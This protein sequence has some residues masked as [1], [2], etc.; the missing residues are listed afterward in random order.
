MSLPII[1]LT[2]FAGNYLN[3]NITE[4]KKEPEKKVSANQIPNGPDIYTSNKLQEVNEVLLKELK[5]NYKKAENP[6]ETGVLPPN[7][8][9]LNAVGYNNSSLIGL[10]SIENAK[11][12][13]INKLSAV[14]KQPAKL[15]SARPMFQ[16]S[17]VAPRQE[18]VIQEEVSLLTG[19]PLV[20]EHSNMTPF[21]GSNIRQNT[22]KFTNDTILSNHTGV[23]SLY[24]HKKEISPLFEPMTENIYGTPIV[25]DKVI[26][27]E[28]YEAS[29][30]RSNEKPFNEQRISAPIANTIDNNIRP[31]Y[32]DVNE[33]RVASK[34]KESYKGKLIEGQR[35]SV[36]GI[37]SEI[38]K[39]RPLT[40]RETGTID[41]WFR[42]PGAYNGSKQKEDFK[43]N[44]PETQRQDSIQYYGASFANDSQKARE[45]ISKEPQNPLQSRSEESKKQNY[46]TDTVR[47]MN[48][49][50]STN[51][52]GKSSFNLADTEREE[53]QDFLLNIHR[54]ESGIR[55]VLQDAAK[56]TQ[57]QTVSDQSFLGNIKTSFDRNKLNSYDI[58]LS[59]NKVKTTTKEQFVKNKYLP[60]V[61]IEKGMGYIVNK[62]TA[63]TTQKEIDSDKSSYIG[64]ADGRDSNMSRENY[65]NAEIREFK[66]QSLK[67]DRASGPQKF[68]INSGKDMQG[69]IKLTN[70]MALK[71]STN[72]RKFVKTSLSQNIL[73]K[74]N[75]GTI[76][77]TREEIK[78]SRLKPEIIQSQIQKNPYALKPHF[79]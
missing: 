52:F 39:N 64:Q 9:T 17:I 37:Q 47:N 44:F 30:I 40:Y 73:S 41:N 54:K 27:P 78:D 76:D 19:K 67:R 28:R 8:N 60:Q 29:R 31:I 66:E 62:Y 79:Q 25:T 12:E 75:I 68:Q 26:V 20:R 58:G 49:Y 63:P 10:S 22:E 48:G 11:L 38:E 33:L 77:K 14:G 42:G 2:L 13:D 56:V 61:S 18:K 72:Q 69:E 36:R 35:G 43:T 4:R 70:K 32:R 23:S 34:P 57:R 1:A 5:E 6:V 21:F 55:T 65:D 74:E 59:E 3:K 7:F 71:E 45:Y 16:E 50:K 51:D 15:I 24:K 53:E 46:K